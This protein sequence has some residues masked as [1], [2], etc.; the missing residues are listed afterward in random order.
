MQLGNTVRV[1]VIYS[2]CHHHQKDKTESRVIKNN[3]L[4][5]MRVSVR[6]H[7]FQAPRLDWVGRH[8]GGVFIF[9]NLCEVV[10]DLS[11]Y[12]IVFLNLLL[13]HRNQFLY[14]YHIANCA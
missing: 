12:I 6:I 8:V 9:V 11:P 1:V 3:K 2:L 4:M 5:L 7:I 10:F 13:S 14:F